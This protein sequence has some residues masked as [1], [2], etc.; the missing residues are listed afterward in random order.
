MQSIPIQFVPFAFVCIF[1]ALDVISGIVRA[2]A[3]HEVSSTR[4]REGLWHKCATLLLVLTAFVMSNA[5]SMYEVIPF[6]CA[7]VYDGICIYV[8]GMELTSILENV[9]T[10]N[11]ELSI[12][13][14]FKLFNIEKKGDE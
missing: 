1:I 5:L 13:K 11:P 14:V 6:D 3:L 12:A 2:C 4:M 10:A 7:Y 9:C 8:I